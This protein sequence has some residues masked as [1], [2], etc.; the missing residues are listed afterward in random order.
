[1]EAVVETLYCVAFFE[2][3]GD[4]AVLFVTW[5]LGGDLLHALFGLQWLEE[6]FLA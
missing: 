5:G 1:M 2:D 6:E 3:F 4:L